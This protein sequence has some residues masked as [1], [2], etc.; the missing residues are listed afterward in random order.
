MLLPKRVKRRMK[1]H[2]SEE[3]ISM[4]VLKE[5][6]DMQKT[7]DRYLLD[8]S[9]AIILVEN[10]DKASHNETY[11][12]IHERLI[13]GKL[14]E[15][16]RW[17]M[18]GYYFGSIHR[19]TPIKNLNLFKVQNGT[20]YFNALY[21]Y[22]NDMFIVPQGDWNLLEFGRDN[23][24]FEQFNGILASF[25]ISSDYDED[26]VVSYTNPITNEK[27][28]ESFRV[29]DGNYYAV[30]NLDGTIKG[31]K[32]FKGIDFSRIKSIIDLSEYGTLTEFK[33]ARKQFCNDEKKAQKQ[34]YY[35]MIESRNDGSISPYLDSKVA[36]ILK[37]KK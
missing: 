1:K 12:M 4:R 3:E 13:D 26:D 33:K 25:S 23:K 11:I 10:N 37:L 15:I 30:L 22:K 36:E 7:E 8:E 21:D 14:K 20:G 5:Y 27:I 28:T 35:S 18:N 6:I 24:Y 16:N 34:N 19:V 17:Y 31:N 2:M 29:R 32:L 9:N